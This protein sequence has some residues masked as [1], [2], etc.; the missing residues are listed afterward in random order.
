MLNKSDQTAL[1][2]SSDK[3]ADALLEKMLEE[4]NQVY[5]NISEAY[6]ASKE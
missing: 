5:E 6:A 2:V 1:L 4:G 3:L